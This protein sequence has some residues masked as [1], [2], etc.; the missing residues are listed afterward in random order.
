MRLLKFRGI[1]L[2][3]EMHYGNL[4]ILQRKYGN[5]D[6]GWYISNPHG[7]P[8][9]YSVKHQT[10]GQFTGMK[11]IHDTEIYEG[12]ILNCGETIEVVKIQRA[13]I[14]P[15]SW[16]SKVVVLGNIHE[17]PNLMNSEPNP[18]RIVAPDGN[19]EE[20]N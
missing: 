15:L 9:A 20:V 11:D 4:T 7:A 1:G 2:D 18:K 16:I 8:F 10:V 6:D 13:Y 3:G 12:D 17:N 14:L 19:K 5:I